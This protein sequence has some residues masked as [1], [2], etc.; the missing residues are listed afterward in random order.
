M[1]DMNLHEENEKYNLPCPY[2][3]NILCVQ[4]PEEP[5]GCD[6]CEE[7]EIFIEVQCY[8]RKVSKQEKKDGRVAPADGKES[9]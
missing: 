5:C 7:C 2:N 8:K 4:Y 3:N 6:P 1:V 9:L